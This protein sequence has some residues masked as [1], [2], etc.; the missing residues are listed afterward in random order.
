METYSIVTTWICRLLQPTV[1]FIGATKSLK[2]QKTLC[3]LQILWKVTKLLWFAVQFVILQ[4]PSTRPTNGKFYELDVSLNTPNKCT[5]YIYLIHTSPTCFSV[6]HT[7]FRENVTYS[8][9]K[10]IWFY[11]TNFRGFTELVM[12]NTIVTVV[13]IVFICKT[14]GS[15]IWNYCGN[16]DRLPFILSMNESGE[17]QSASA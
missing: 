8:L 15:C 3:F 7:A 4:T 6:F 13:L 1:N 10:T 9:L 11:K 14:T 17:R 16:L 2:P 5:L 12:N